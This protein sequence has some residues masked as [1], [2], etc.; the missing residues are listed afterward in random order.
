MQG[1]RL[2]QS[3]ETRR[4][5]GQKSQGE[6]PPQYRKSQAGEDES[7][8]VYLMKINA[9]GQIESSTSVIKT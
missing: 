1:I 6:M 9:S 7:S 8:K 4:Q 3:T 2:V 5:T